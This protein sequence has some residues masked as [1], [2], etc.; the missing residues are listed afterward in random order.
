MSKKQTKMNF[1]VE[2]PEGLKLA[3]KRIQAD[4]KRKGIPYKLNHITIEA[5]RWF[6]SLS[7]TELCDKCAKALASCHRTADQTGEPASIKM[8]LEHELAHFFFVRD[9]M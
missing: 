5:L 2:P 9:Q 4:R 3:I 6:V 8:S 1:H 7:Q